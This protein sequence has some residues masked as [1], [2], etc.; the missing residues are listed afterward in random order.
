MANW[1]GWGG[2][3]VWRGWGS[4]LPGLA[5]TAGIGLAAWWVAG[6]ERRFLGHQPL[7]PLVLALLL[8]MSL[9]TFCRVPARAEPGIAYAAKQVLEGAIVILGATLNLR[10]ITAAGLPLLLCIL[11]GVPLAI[12]V[13]IILGRRLALSTRLAVLIAVGNAVC[14]NSAIAAVAPA[15]RARKQEIAS[16]VALTAILGAGVALALPPIGAALGL[17]EA[18]YGI[19]AGMIVYAVPQVL[20]ATLPFGP[21]A[22]AIAAAVK[23][24]RVLLLG[25]IVAVFA[26]LFRDGDDQPSRLSLRRCVPWFVVGFL[27]LAALRTIGVVGADLGAR[28]GTLSRTLTI[29][30]MA[31]LGLGVDLRAIRTVGPR[32]ACAVIGSL[33][34]LAAFSLACIFLFRLGA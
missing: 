34:L 18:R 20:V 31:G 27:T 23:L 26:L 12:G 10:A 11:V 30:A 28:A 7:E 24:T 2:G 5:L 21:Q 6:L 25:P 22:A 16:A 19:L 17:G 14:G 4:L 13:S 9:R 1:R 33:S 3:R 29:L 32:V 8:G 15:I